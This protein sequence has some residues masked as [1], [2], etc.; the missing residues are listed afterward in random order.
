MIP[1]RALIL[2]SGAALGLLA[3][4]S[5]ETPTGPFADA[6]PELALVKTYTAVDLG[7]L[8][9]MASEATGINPSG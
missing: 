1:M 6:R 5:A 2:F 7:T 3:C 8:G 9:G 4:T